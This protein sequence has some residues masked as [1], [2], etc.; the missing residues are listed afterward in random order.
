MTEQST[1]EAVKEK[2]RDRDAEALPSF[3]DCKLSGGIYNGHSPTSHHGDA[4]AKDSIDEEEEKQEKEEEEEHPSI[5][6]MKEG[7]SAALVDAVLQL[8]GY[9]VHVLCVINPDSSSC[10]IL[11]NG[12]MI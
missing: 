1:G 10:G 9:Q 11:R 12:N 3:S 2:T 6:R 8:D 5:T 4:D 7:D